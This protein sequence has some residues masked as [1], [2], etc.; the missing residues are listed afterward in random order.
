MTGGTRDVNPQFLSDSAGQSAADTTTTTAVV[1]PVQRIASNAP[2]QAVIV[3]VL[4]VF[5]DF[6]RFP[7]I[8]TVTE[9]VD[10]MSIAFT[11]RNQGTT[12]TNLSE[13]TLFA[14]FEKLRSG[15][16]TAAGTYS[17]MDP[18]IEAFDLTDG[19]GHGVLI[20]T[21]QIFVQVQSIGTGNANTLHFKILYR[22]KR[23]P[24]TEYIGIVQSQQ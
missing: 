18:Q 13:P 4:K 23:V 10:S 1:L 5:I 6:P 14:R 20:A 21:D 16:F 7:D 22:W 15:A 19:A 9:A 2:N 3:E 24:L 12:L 8:A 17:M 11:T